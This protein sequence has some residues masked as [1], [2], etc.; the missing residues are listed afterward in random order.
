MT[1]RRGA[2]SSQV[3][4]KTAVEESEFHE[5]AP[6]ASQPPARRYGTRASTQTSRP[7]H[8]LGLHK[9][10]KD[11]IHAEA[12]QKRLQKEAKQ[13]GKLEK[14]AKLARDLKTIAELEDEQLNMQAE[15]TA[16]LD[17]P[18]RSPSRT[19]DGRE[20]LS[21]RGAAYGDMDTPD[22]ADA[23]ADANA[24]SGDIDFDSHPHLTRSNLDSSDAY[25]QDGDYAH[26]KVQPNI[27]DIFSD[28][29]LVDVD[30]DSESTRRRGKGKQRASSD[31]EAQWAQDD[32]A[33]HASPARQQD[34]AASDYDSVDEAHAQLLSM[35][36]RETER[37][38]ARVS[39]PGQ[40]SHASSTQQSSSG[41]SVR[42]RAPTVKR[43]RH[44]VESDPED[45]ADHDYHPSVE[46]DDIDD[47]SE[48]D[49]GGGT[50]AYRLSR[51]EQREIKRTAIRGQIQMHRVLISP[52]TL[53]KH[54]RDP[55]EAF[56]APVPKRGR[57]NQ[58]SAFRPN[59]EDRVREQSPSP[60][61]Q[62]STRATTTRTPAHVSGH[63][64]SSRPANAT[65][66]SS[67][68]AAQARSST[69]QA[70]SS[71]AST[72][73]RFERR[74]A[75]PNGSDIERDGFQHSDIAFSREY[76]L[77]TVK[78]N[79]Q[80]HTVAIEQ[81]TD[82]E[83][84]T[85]DARPGLKRRRKPR[86][87]VD[88]DK[89]R[90][91]TNVPDFIKPYLFNDL[92]PTVIEYYGAKVD[93]WNS[94][95]HGRDELLN[96]CQDL[97]NDLCPRA[98]YHL[99]KQDILYKVIQQ[100]IYEWRSGFPNA[101]VSIINDKI[102]ELFGANPKRPQ[103]QTWVRQ[104][105]ADGGEALWGK[106]DNRHPERARG[107]LQSRYVLGAFGTHLAATDGA[108]YVYGPPVGALSLAATAVQHVLGMYK[109]G[110]FIP[111]KAFSAANVSYL[112]ES[113]Y[114]KA[115]ARYARNEEKFRKLV[116]KA[117]KHATVAKY[118][119]RNRAGDA[120]QAPDL[121]DRSSPPLEDTDVEMDEDLTDCEFAFPACEP[122]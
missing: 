77:S 31:D 79:K 111:G 38:R 52:S 2:A 83:A 100:E 110:K 3:R 41:Q 5:D 57:S 120:L 33:I 59:W 49:V 65:P 12:Q 4:D 70:R 113:W 62:A 104:A 80:K 51:P 91:A 72:R 112:T 21:G 1:G 86:T 81:V 116:R 118:H 88:E 82:D 99:T 29:E 53:K 71:G 56:L 84:A 40:S 10:T 102:F 17:Q 35:L 30:L 8:A 25:V 89:S 106:P 44:I 97:I 16:L 115:V 64:T 22:G 43:A 18:R 7:A 6:Q 109:T 14:A 46:I 96:L 27:D 23:N 50:Q 92:I 75:D 103:V 66:A 28:A 15:E 78:R 9:R 73:V 67:R 42:R 119:T 105:L 121:F 48:E 63:L 11:E 19:L 47:E 69:S 20:P 107:S 34:A 95:E 85:C 68:A 101:V 58:G 60:L 122:C 76:A 117:T 90:S 37:D 45:R 39:K 87:Q 93:P 13:K 94:Q 55:T 114:R 36:R 61:H 26:G 108:I 32:A 24:D 54:S 74:M 98:D